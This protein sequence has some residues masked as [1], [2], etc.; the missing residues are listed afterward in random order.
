MN[1]SL[2]RVIT[3]LLIVCLLG[4]LT[5]VG[6]KLGD[7]DGESGTSDSSNTLQTS[8]Q[9]GTDSKGSPSDGE[10]S[11]GSNSNE[12]RDD[13]PKDSKVSF[14]ACG[15]NLIHPSVYYDA[16]ETA[17]RNKGVSPV[18]SNLQS[19]EYDFD[20][21]YED[22]EEEIAAADIAYINVESLVG[23][24]GF[25]VSG[26]PRFNSPNAVGEKLLK[27]GYDVFN[28]AHNHMLDVSGALA[29]CD[30]F[31]SSR[32]GVALGYY[33][34]DAAVYDIPVIEKNGIK[35]AFLTYTYSTNGLSLPS[36]S[37]INIPYFDEDL[38]R[39]QVAE[40][41]KVSD[42]IIVSCHWGD[43]DKHIPNSSQ[44]KY[45]SLFVELGIEIVLGMHPHTI[46][47]IDWV[48]N[49]TG[50]R[51]LVVYSL[52]N[53]LSGMYNGFNHLE[54]TLSLNIVK[55][56]STGE[57]SI[58]DVVFD[59]VV[60][61]FTL[62]ESV[63]GTDTGHRNYKIY[64]LY[65]YTEQLALE[66]RIRTREREYGT[67]LVGGAFTLENL[68]KTVNTYINQEFLPEYMQD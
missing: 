27:L 22:F 55:S 49:P 63:D 2:I 32:G 47:R 15:D 44:E 5:I 29:G 4:A 9:A 41:R 51:T 12:S 58:E 1:K 3:A 54:G 25:S 46:Q 19:Q 48:D 21:M 13:T 60:V 28:L 42:L 7:S 56:A 68:Y 57:I 31:F 20:R 65:D 64:H 17:A 38:I 66:H 30:E 35:T 59:P 24:S 14:F 33:E 6:L 10:N 43:E 16:L 8:S 18:Y 62:G 26:Y 34:N 50:G 45:A 67:T 61:H 37:S 52:G 39:L 23:G 40:A 53:F 11:G 36:S